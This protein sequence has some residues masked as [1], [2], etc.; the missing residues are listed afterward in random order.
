MDGFDSYNTSGGLIALQV[1]NYW[2][3][4]VFSGQGM[5]M[6]GGKDNR[7]Y[8]VQMFSNNSLTTPNID[9]ISGNNADT[10][11]G[12]NFYVTSLSDYSAND[13]TTLGLLRALGTVNSAEVVI[14]QGYIETGIDTQI[15]IANNTWHHLEVKTFSISSTQPRFRFEVYLNGSLIYTTTSDS[16]SGFF[17]TADHHNLRATA[18]N[19]IGNPS[20]VYIDNFYLLDTVGTP[21]DLLGPSATVE[22]LFPSGSIGNNWTSVIGAPTPHEAVDNVPFDQYQ[23]ILSDTPGQVQEFLF[24]NLE[25][26]V[27]PLSVEVNSVVNGNQDVFQ[28]TRNG[29]VEESFGTISGN[30]IYSNIIKSINGID[31]ATLTVND[32]NNIQA[33][34]G[35]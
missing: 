8:S 35:S 23:L 11:V 9:A 20:P 7:G 5:S 13:N 27:T 12:F 3:N 4:A 19:A 6:A 2:G 32:V 22:T 29:S 15:A 18:S 21:N 30:R 24:D 14:K 1:A 16:P 17:K 33:G 34:V 25:E 28:H 31:D 10:I 26:I